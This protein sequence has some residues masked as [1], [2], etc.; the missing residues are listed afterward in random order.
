MT[1]EE[2]AGILGKKYKLAQKVITGIVNDLF[3]IIRNEV[4][5]G[6]KIELRRLGT[7]YSVVERLKRS[8]L[9]RLKDTI[10]KPQRTIRF[11]TAR[12]WKDE[13]NNKATYAR[14]VPPICTICNKPFVL[15]KDLPLDN[16]CD[17]CYRQYI[18]E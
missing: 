15:N 8:N 1:K 13:I 18:A 16:V 4:G 9:P 14:P 10:L 12:S 2:I 7:F 5:E 17:N 11:K 6:R 3:S